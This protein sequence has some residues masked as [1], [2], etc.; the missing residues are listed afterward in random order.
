MLDLC[1]KDWRE[2]IG[3]GEDEEDI[4][5]LRMLVGLVIMEIGKGNVL[6]I[7]G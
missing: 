3:G 6:D 1:V 7:L 2:G 5:A 4:P